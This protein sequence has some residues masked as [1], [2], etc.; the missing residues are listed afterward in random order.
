MSNTDLVPALM[1]LVVHNPVWSV[2]G[3]RKSRV[4]GSPAEGQSQPGGGEGT[5]E[6]MPPML[7]TAAA[8]ELTVVKGRAVQVKGAWRWS[9][10]VPP[11]RKGPQGWSSGHLRWAEPVAGSGR[12]QCQP[13]T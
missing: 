5:R 10:L 8:S 9:N 6:V 12:Q 7:G 3:W 2:Q 11:A 1:A 4:C 13:E